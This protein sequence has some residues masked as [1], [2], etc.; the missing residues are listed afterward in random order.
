MTF[1]NCE[2]GLTQMLLLVV[3]E[4][5]VLCTVLHTRDTWLRRPVFYAVA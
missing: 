5:S 3:S 2:D 1:D 4:V